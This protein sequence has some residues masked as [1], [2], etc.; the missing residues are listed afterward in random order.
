MVRYLR[1][2]NVLDGCLDLTDVKEMNFTPAEQSVFR[3]HDGDILVTEGSGSIRAVGASAV[4]R[5]ELAGPVC[6]QNTLLRVRPRAGTDSR[7]LAWWCRHA[8]ADGLF[9]SV[10]AGANIFHLSAERV[11]ALPMLERPVDEQRAVAGYLD[12]ETARVDALLAAQERKALLLRERERA[13]RTQ[14]ALTASDGVP[15]PLRR[16]KFLSPRIGVGL[17]INPSTY[18]T[19]SGVPF[20]HGSHITESGISL[21]PPRYMSADDSR[22]L[23]QS[24]LHTGDV[25][26]VR[27][28]YPGRAAVVPA[29]LEGANSASVIIV[30]RSERLIPQFLVECLNSADGERQVGL[31]QYGAAQE[32]I[33]VSHIVNFEI[34]A[35]DLEEQKAVLGRIERVCGPLRDSRT[36]IG[37]QRDLLK[38]RRQALITAAVTGEVPVPVPVPT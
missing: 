21:V 15:Y 2:A 11:R 3:L 32:Q 17:V 18:A 13:V 20:V 37:R 24:E 1:A 5:S 30:R 14:L 8:F 9:A 16:L 29:E 35:P 38:E 28:G 34:P 4:W 33:N 7:Y 31:T 27:A 36:L 25:V 23:A 12:R 6:F 26:V 10:A 19:D 22:R